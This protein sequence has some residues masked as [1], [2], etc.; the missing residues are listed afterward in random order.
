[1]GS[2]AL[3]VSAPSRA[4][5]NRVKANAAASP[6]LARRMIPSRDTNYGAKR[7]LGAFVPRKRVVGKTAP[8]AGKRRLGLFLKDRTKIS[9]P[10]QYARDFDAAVVHAIKN[11]IRVS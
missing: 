3:A 6:V 1:M 4:P 2:A 10:V 5:L 9:P 8:D 11:H 7:C